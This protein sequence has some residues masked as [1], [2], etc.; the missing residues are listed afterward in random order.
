VQ[1]VTRAVLPVMREQKSG[2]IL[3]ISSVGGFA[4]APG[5]GIYGATKFAVEG[6]S[7]AARRISA[8]GIQVVIIEPGSFRTDFLDGTSLHPASQVIEDYATTAGQVRNQ[9]T[10]RNHSQVNVRPGSWA[11]RRQ[12]T[13]VPRGPH[14]HRHLLFLDKYV[15]GHDRTDDH[16][17]AR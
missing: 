10:A 5:W 11:I 15:L 8:V 16:V 9:A 6:L 4:Q 3:N 7:S 17:L 2:R 14:H 1:S 12:Q 13:S